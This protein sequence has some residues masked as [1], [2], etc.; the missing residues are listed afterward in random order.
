M[1]ISKHVAVDALRRSGYPE[2]ADVVMAE[3][4]ESI[5]VNKLLHLV[6]PFGIRS[7]D[8]LIAAMGGSP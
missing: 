2:A 4:Q 6:E 7:I 8:N 3:P 1:D 5:D